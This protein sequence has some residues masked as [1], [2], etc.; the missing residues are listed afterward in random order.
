MNERFRKAFLDELP[1]RLEEI[2][3]MLLALERGGSPH[4]ALADLYRSVH[5]IKGSAATFGQQILAAIC[6]PFE[7]IIQDADQ[8]ETLPP[9]LVEVALGYLELLRHSVAEIKHGCENFDGTEKKLA[10]LHERAFQQRFSVAIVANSR[11]LRQIC[12][13]T[14]KAF[15]ARVVEFEDSLNAMHRILGEPFHLVIV[16]S[17][18]YPMRGEALIASMKLSR[19]AQALKAVLVSSDR[20]KAGFVKR[21]VDPDFVVLRDTRFLSHLHD[22][23]GEVYGAYGRSDKTTT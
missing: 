6:H 4:D 19:R 18:L 7:E 2:E 5:S 20:D 17:E 1:E 3:R 12:C 14:A 22:V 10:R 23:I 15:D 13:E 8:A 11:T 16:S 21:D 9:S